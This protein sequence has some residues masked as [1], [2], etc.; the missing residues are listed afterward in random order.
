MPFDVNSAIKEGYAPNEIADFLGQQKKFDV[1]AAR[2]EGYTDE[3]IISHLNPIPK[4]S[5]IGTSFQRGLETICLLYT[6][7]AA[8]E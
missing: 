3:E 5:T 2:K 1:N 8:D 7:D 6:S 4:K